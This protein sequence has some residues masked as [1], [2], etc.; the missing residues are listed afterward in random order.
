MACLFFIGIFRVAGDEIELNLAKIRLQNAYKHS[1]TNSRITLSENR[2]YLLIGDLDYLLKPL[3]ESK[4]DVS[5]QEVQAASASNSTSVSKAASG[6]DVPMSIIRISNLD[7]VCQILK[8]SIRD[9]PES[10]LSPVVFKQLVD[11]T[12][13]FE[14]QAISSILTSC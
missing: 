14:Q 13:V 5:Q 10:L 8:M 11:L 6:E 3:K 2:D 1:C 7:T 4:L 12:K 9:L